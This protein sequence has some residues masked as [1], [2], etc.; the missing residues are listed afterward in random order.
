MKLISVII[1]VYN[2]EKYL[3]QCIQSLVNQTHENMEIILV[4]DGSTDGSG[5]IC[6]EWMNKDSR[7]K[8]F[9]KGNGG[10]M[11]A[12][13]YGV[14]RASGEYI[15]SVDSDDWVEANM[16][17]ELLKAGQANNA[18]LVVCSFVHEN[19]IA[20]KQETFLKDGAYSREDIEQKVYPILLRNEKY[21]Q[22]G[23]VASRWA[24]LFKKDVLLKILPFCDEQVSIGDDLLTTFAMM[25]YVQ[26]LVVLGSFFPYHYRE[27]NSSIIRSFSK[28]KY[29][30]AE[31]LKVAMLKAAKLHEYDFTEQIHGDYIA[32]MLQQIEMEILSTNKGFKSL[33]ESIKAQTK[34]ISFCESLKYIDKKKLSF[35]FR[36]YLFL[37]KHNLFLLMIFIRKLKK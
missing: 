12:W 34:S 19:D 14:E 37:I 3:D 24:K 25:A 1:S 8:V 4:D 35:K 30:K 17:E 13:K 32:L 11:S 27:T 9:H 21:S 26:S 31:N 22:R 33:K 10:P 36:L 29:Q 23:L 6:D 7:I 28:V 16:F 18:E 2:V 15:G 5:V 20:Y